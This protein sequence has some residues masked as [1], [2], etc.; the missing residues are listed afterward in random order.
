MRPLRAKVGLIGH[1]S[2]F[3]VGWAP[4]DRHLVF[5][6][7]TNRATQ[8]RGT[9]KYPE[10]SRAIVRR[11][12]RTWK[13]WHDGCLFTPS[14]LPVAKALVRWPLKTASLEVM[15]LAVNTEDC[16]GSPS[17]MLRHDTSFPDV[18]LATHRDGNRLYGGSLRDKGSIFFPGNLLSAFAAC[19][20]LSRSIPTPL[21]LSACHDKPR[22]PL[23]R[24]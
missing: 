21:P 4:S 1:R 20:E 12:R 2:L 8:I 19:C 16:E 15:T 11:G 9:A 6:A 23:D 18:F 3:L 10:R 22:A 5:S 7:K 13:L 24:A 17:I 14:G